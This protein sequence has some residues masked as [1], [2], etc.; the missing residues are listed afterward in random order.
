MIAGVGL[1]GEIY[2][3]AIAFVGVCAWRLVNWRST[4]AA[5]GSDRRLLA[6]G[7]LVRLATRTL[8][9]AVFGTVLIM[10][11]AAVLV[12]NY[13]RE[14]R[15]GGEF[16]GLQTAVLTVA[17]Y[18]IVVPTANW[19]G[20]WLLAVRPA[21]LAAFGSWMFL[22]TALLLVQQQIPGGAVQPAWF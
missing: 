12:A 13:H 2:L 7:H 11:L 6:T 5:P 15:T 1:L 3:G 14:M 22:G 20:M 9:A 18:V 4:R 21:S 10:V 17:V 8:L 19:L 16:R